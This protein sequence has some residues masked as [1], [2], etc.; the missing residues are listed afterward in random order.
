MQFKRWCLV[1]ARRLVNAGA[2]AALTFL[3]ACGPGSEDRGAADGA[4]S[5]ASDRENAVPD[6]VFTLPAVWST[7][8]LDGPVADIAL[9]GGASSMMAVAYENRGLEMFNLEADR[10]AQIVRFAVR[11]LANGEFVEIDGA[12]VTV[13]PGIDNEGAVNAYVYG[14]GLISPVEIALPIKVDG[15]AVGL[16]SSRARI[17]DGDFMRI[18]YW[19]QKRPDRLEIGILGIKSGEFTWRAAGQ[20]DFGAEI[21]ACSLEGGTQVSGGETRALARLERPGLSVR[22]RLGSDGTLQ[23]SAGDGAAMTLGLREGLSVRVPVR[24]VAIAALGSPFG[25][26]YPGGLVV[27]AGETGENVHQVAFVDAAALTDLSAGGE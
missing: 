6:E 24:P 7:S 3:A 23:A 22:I 14:D 8:A 18:G 25:G 5:H 16:C 9:A 19:T 27:V 13:F 15:E 12:G 17:E 1:P 10:V 21:S 26:G 2:L 20:N 4:G 11:D